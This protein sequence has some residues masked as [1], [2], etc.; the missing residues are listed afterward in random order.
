MAGYL[1][2]QPGSDDALQLTNRHGEL[3]QHVALADGFN[4]LAE[5]LSGEVPVDLGSKYGRLLVYLPPFGQL[6]AIFIIYLTKYICLCVFLNITRK[7]KTQKFKKHQ[8]IKIHQTGVF[9]SS[10]KS[11]TRQL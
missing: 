4:D 7:L 1:L 3:P 9:F 10:C 8:N 5:M 6:S 2:E 11:E